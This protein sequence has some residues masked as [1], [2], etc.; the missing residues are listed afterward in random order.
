MEQ[1]EY[2]RLTIFGSEAVGQL[3][4]PDGL[5]FPKNKA[6]IPSLHHGRS[7]AVRSNDFEWI[8]VKGGGWNYNGP[9]VYLSKKDDELVFGLNPYKAGLREYEVSKKI[10][11]FSD[12]FP[13]VL[14]I[15]RFADYDLPNEFD[16]LK[17][18]R[19]SNGE[20]VDPCLTYTK[21]KC[22]YRVA[23]LAYLTDEKKTTLIEK[24]SDYFDVAKCDFVDKFTSL[25]AERVG[26]LH[27]RGFINDTL[28]YGNVT[29]LAEIVD[30]ELVTAPG[31]LFS[32][33]TY[34]TEIGDARREKELLYGAEISMQ[35]NALLHKR[36]SLYD[37]YA[38]FVDSYKKYNP[39][40]VANNRTVNEILDRKK[41][42]I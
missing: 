31:V 12:D 7:I 23:E 2:G 22:P 26:F 25:L 34:G 30:Y 15:R 37:S 40:F 18:I 35:L 28:E 36:Y 24:Y 9:L 4:M 10:E 27:S 17:N 13:K 14:Y 39:E 6:F 16:F 29:L 20:L 3:F 33:G 41:I 11:E 38:S 21:V 1:N 32:D 19:Y 8:L 5:S 42:V